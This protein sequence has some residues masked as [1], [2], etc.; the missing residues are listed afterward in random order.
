MATVNPGNDAFSGGGIYRSAPPTSGPTGSFPALSST[1]GGGPVGGVAPNA[2]PFMARPNSGTNVRIPYSRVVPLSDPRGGGLT[3][4]TKAEDYYK[5]P[6]HKLNGFYD[7]PVMSE[8]DTL[9]PTRLAFILA[10]R[11][12]GQ[13]SLTGAGDPN[14]AFT[15]LD[16]TQQ[17]IS[18]AVNSTLA[19]QLPGVDRFQKLCSLEYL[20]RY[21]NVTVNIYAE[22][23]KR[24]IQLAGGPAV[25]KVSTV[26]P[27]DG[28][29]WSSGLLR[30][31][32]ERAVDRVKTLEG[33]APG[34]VQTAGTAG[35]FI[36]VDTALY[37]D[38]ITDAASPVVT[39]ADAAAKKEAIAAIASTPEDNPARS[40]K[41][42]GFTGVPPLDAT[43]C[44]IGDLAK[45]AA[46]FGSPL[47]VDPT[48]T[49]EANGD[50][51]VVGEMLDD[52]AKHPHR[53]QGIFCSDTTCF[54]RGRGIHSEMVEAS[55]Y[56]T[57]MR[58]QPYMLSRNLGDEVAFALLERE[59][60][61]IGL[62]DWTPDGILLSKLDNV[63]EDALDDQRIDARDGMLYNL[64]IQGPCIASNWCG[65]TELAVM[66]TDKV[67]VLVIADC[68]YEDIAYAGLEAGISEYMNAAGNKYEAYKTAKKSIMTTDEL[69]E[70]GNAVAFNTRAEDEHKGDAANR[71]LTNFRLRL[72]TSSEMIHDSGLTYDQATKKPTRRARMGLGISMRVTEYVVGG[73]CIGTIMDSAASRAVGNLGAN[74]GVRTAPNTAAH[75]LYVNVEWWNG[76]RLYR[77]YANVEG[78]TRSR[79]DPPKVTTDAAEQA[80]PSTVEIGGTEQFK[81][82]PVQL[83]NLPREA[84]YDD[85]VGSIAVAK[86]AQKGGQMDAQGGVEVTV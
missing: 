21:I 40:I 71:T 49:E 33:K 84:F 86:N 68:W 45:R 19:P 43:L 56:D 65:K 47:S 25:T 64:A 69:V 66:P 4:A 34:T 57:T 79:H 41:P 75:S 60:M 1:P 7:K 18:Y 70:G 76:D 52:D 72:S 13:S 14:Y 11:S 26:V 8:T 46:E 9:M 20:E 77:S 73:W 82:G 6:D 31:V 50:V 59:L 22:P 28:L 15:A 55:N 35:T 23:A 48:I 54:L 80:V 36:G 83:V 29:G 58:G 63:P 32:Y 62:F 67:F 37:N 51:K 42:V 10:K 53:A 12:F 39:A 44:N 27:R 74:I 81:L 17:D 38:V 3:E 61:S 24:K 5:T 85:A 78:L 30:Q 16:G 2:T